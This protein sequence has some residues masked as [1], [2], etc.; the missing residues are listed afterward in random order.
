MSKVLEG[1]PPAMTAEHFAPSAT[2][3]QA[4]GARLAGMEGNAAATRSATFEQA[5]GGRLA[6]IWEGNAAATPSATFEQATGTSKVS[7]GTPP[8]MTAEHFAPSATFEQ[9]TGARLAGMKSNAATTRSATFEQATGG[10][11]AGI[12]GGNVAATPSATFEQATGMSKVL[13]GTPPAM[14]AE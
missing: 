5:T 2:F 9:A 10:G 12:W 6:G 8:A 1:T 13:E 4:M 3:E 14:T 11:L 7:E